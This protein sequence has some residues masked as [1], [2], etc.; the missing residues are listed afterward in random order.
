M[1]FA[2]VK[3]FYL[4]TPMAEPEYMRIALVDIPEEIINEYNL[5]EIVHTDGYVYIQINGGM[6]GL[7]Q[8]GILANKLLETRLRPHGYYQC[9]HSRGLWKHVTRP[10]KFALI[11]DDFGMQYVGKQHADHLLNL[12]KKHYEGVSIDWDASLFS[13]ITFKWDWDKRTCDLSM[14]GYIESS[15]ERFQHPKPTKPV[16]APHRFNPPQYGVKVQLTA[17]ADRSAPLQPSGCKRIQQIVGTLLFYGRAVDSTLLMTLS[18]LASRQTKAT[19]QDASDTDHLLNYCATHPN[20]TLRYH[21][22]DMILKVHSDASYLSESNARSRTGGHFYLGNLPDKPE[23]HNGAILNPAGILKMVVAAASE[24]ELAALFT[25]MKEALI[26]RQILT[27]LGRPQPPTPVITDNSTAAGIANDTIRQQKSRAV[28]MRFHWVRDR[29]AQKQ[30]EVKWKRAQQNLADY[31]TKHHAP[32][33]HQ[34]MRPIY[35]VNSAQRRQLLPHGHLADLK[36]CEGVLNSTGLNGV[37]IDKQRQPICELRPRTFQQRASLT[38][39]VAR[40][41]Q[42]NLLP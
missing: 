17:P 25:N 16:H 31:F 34:T 5:R 7:P 35:L 6:Y 18:S 30:F 8:A 1:V 26:V 4:N 19:E 40:P 32:K 14:P 12:L 29:V 42:R 2:D 39:L 37:P 33:H 11:V 20:A 13:G 10:I 28:D 21:A 23:V 36:R 41:R 15:L 9:R 22:S 27:D 38:S 24:A 3:N